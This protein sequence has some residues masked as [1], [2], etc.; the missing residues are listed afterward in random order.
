[1]SHKNG[2]PWKSRYVW[3]HALVVNS[4]FLSGFF[5][6]PSSTFNYFIVVHL[7]IRSAGDTWAQGRFWSDAWDLWRHR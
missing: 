1:M 7:S 2:H 6:Y 5:L 4:I 3:S